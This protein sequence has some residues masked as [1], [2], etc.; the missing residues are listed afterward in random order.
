LQLSTERR[1]T[2]NDTSKNNN[3]SILHSL[4]QQQK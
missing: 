4:L 3:I 1:Q 2:P